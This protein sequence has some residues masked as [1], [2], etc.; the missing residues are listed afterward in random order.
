MVAPILRHGWAFLA[1]QQLPARR[2]CGAKIAT[3]LTLRLAPAL[4]IPPS[5]VKN[6]ADGIYVGMAGAAARA[7][8]L[9]SIADNLANAE[10]PGFKAA[11][12]AFSSFLPGRGPT[13]KVFS[14]AVATGIDLRPG[15]TVPTDNPLDVIPEGDLFLGVE[16]AP[17][18]QG[19][20][21][22]GKITVDT[23]GKLTVAG[24]ALL[25]ASGQPIVVPVGSAPTMNENGDVMVDG[26]V[27]DRVG[28]FE[29]QGP[30]D[31]NG[32][33]ILTAGP[34]ATVT[35]VEG[36]LRVGELELGNAPPLESTIAMITAQRNFD[37]AMQAIQT[38][39]RLDEKA[40]EVG[41]VR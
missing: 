9:E 7:A 22:N 38:Y 28:L 17:G 27:V 15:T 1:R 11:R 14:A 18:Q 41:R 19:Y 26:A 6:V 36:S 23:D 25:G 32:L 5:E 30:V 16:M 31:R 39:R 37:S 40:T 21:R 2:K 4:L 35:E 8:Q 13:D 29:V 3:S 24:H 33:S 12:P 10:T 20:T 34:G